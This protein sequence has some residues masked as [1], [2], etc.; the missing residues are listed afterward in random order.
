M[1]GDAFGQIT[2]PVDPPV[3][4]EP[5]G[6][7]AVAVMLGYFKA[8]LNANAGDAWDAVA[9][10]TLP[11]KGTFAANPLESDFNEKS[12]PALYLNR[13]APHEAPVWLA[14]DW[15]VNADVMRLQWVFPKAPQEKQ[16]MRT[17]IT[18]ALAKCVEVA[19]ERERDACFV[20][21]GDPDP[22]ADTLDALPSAIKLAVATSTSPVTYSGA[23]L[24]G[25]VGALAISPPRAGTVTASGDASAFASG[26]T[27]TWSGTNVLG[28]TTSLPVAITA[29][30]TYSTPNAL[31][32]VTSIDVTAAD[33]TGGTLSFG[34]GP[35]QGRGTVIRD[36]TRFYQWFVATWRLGAVV[37][38]MADAEP[39]HYRSLEVDIV[40]RE[41]LD[42]DLTDTIRYSPIQGIDVSYLL[43]DGSVSETQS[44]PDNSGA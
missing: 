11:V 4:G 15:Y 21:V 17:N 24:D 2:I 38:Q 37:I 31:K 16:S 25:S 19:V 8:F 43:S 22:T 34:L 32:S 27:V 42:Q 7:P 10:R 36:F 33:G 41:K 29:A 6:D 3:N 26:V 5:A 13:V 18:N 40:V 30:G 20:I 44:L 35:Y 14:A 23:Q 1:A 39:R 9:P 28:L 12:L